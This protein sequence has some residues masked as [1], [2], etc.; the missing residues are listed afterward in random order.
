MKTPTHAPPV[1]SAHGVVDL[2]SAATTKPAAAAGT[3]A[4]TASET[5]AATASTAAAAKLAI[6]TKSAAATTAAATAPGPIPKLT[7]T[8]PPAAKPTA[9]TPASVAALPAPAPTALLPRVSQ[10]SGPEGTG[11]RRRLAQAVKGWVMLPVGRPYIITHLPIPARTIPQHPAPSRTSLLF[12][13]L[14]PAPWDPVV[15][16]KRHWGVWVGCGFDGLGGF[17]GLGV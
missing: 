17:N 7:A 9:A 6:A 2:S 10:Q 14:G 4:G 8:A 15:A 11:G 16:Y 5:P 13:I 1:S 12:H 3:P